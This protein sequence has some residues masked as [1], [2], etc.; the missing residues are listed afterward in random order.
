[1]S[2]REKKKRFGVRRELSISFLSILSNY[3][4][5]SCN[6]AKFAEIPDLTMAVLIIMVERETAFIKLEIHLNPGKVDAFY[7]AS[8]NHRLAK[9]AREIE[10]FAFTVPPGLPSKSVHC[11]SPFFSVIL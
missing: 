1:M 7:I 5:S 8:P 4:K 6:G 11:P 2:L 9:T 10:A 3:I